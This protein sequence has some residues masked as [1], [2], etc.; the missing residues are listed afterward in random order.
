VTTEGRAPGLTITV[1]NK[2]ARISH[3]SSR[4]HIPFYD[5]DWLSRP[6]MRAERPSLDLNFLR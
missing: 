6:P 3:F 5:V 1:E 4:I 2:E